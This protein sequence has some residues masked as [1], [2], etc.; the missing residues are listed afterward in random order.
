MADLVECTVD[1]GGT[2]DYAS[3]N[4]A[5]AA[6]FGAPSANLV[7]DDKYVEC[8]C[9]CTNGAAD[10]TAVTIA[11]QT[12]DAT[13]DITI[14]VGEGYRHDGT[15]P[16]SGNVY[17]LVVTGSYAVRSYVDYT[18]IGWL[19]IQFTANTDA[20]IGLGI[21]LCT[22]NR[23]HH[24]IVAVATGGYSTVRCIRGDDNSA[25]ASELYYNNIVMGLDEPAAR[26]IECD[27][28][29][30]D[31][32]AYNNTVIDCSI[33]FV[34][35]LT[36][37]AVY[38]KNNL[39]FNCTDCFYGT[40]HGD[41]TNNMYSEGT[42]PGSNG[43]SIAAYAGG[44]IFRDYNNNDFHLKQGSPCIGAGADLSAEGITDDIDGD[45]RSSWDVGADEY[46]PTGGGGAGV[47]IPPREQIRTFDDCD[48]GDA[49]TAHGDV[50]SGP[51]SSLGNVKGRACI[52]V[53]RAGDKGFILFDCACPLGYTIARRNYVGVWIGLDVAATFS[54][55]VLGFR[56]SAGRI[57]TIRLR[58]FGGEYSVFNN[59]WRRGWN[60]KVFDIS[61]VPFGD[62]QNLRLLFKYGRGYRGR[63]FRIDEIKMFDD[64]RDL[65]YVQ[66]PEQSR[67]SLQAVYPQQQNY[68]G[69]K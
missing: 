34:A 2:G 65:S 27:A 24:T 3:L 41:S 39:A 40:F 59:M 45:T 10:T 68:V 36:A 53:D 46:V 54:T 58:D 56:P 38:S 50:A 52:Q 67:A 62:I 57:H 28:Y 9:I 37:G 18:D 31:V 64:L 29:T 4:L 33:G 44:Q 43:T 11:G 26:G 15:L 22:G 69:R 47:I 19:P 14:T 7:A 6:N 20:A 32:L 16:T 66:S 5:E 17:R 1:P 61:N 55:V 49:W 23:V 48:V 35:F 60:Y 13:R 30:V 8:T 42:D 21:I 51:Y 12:T 25:G 63:S